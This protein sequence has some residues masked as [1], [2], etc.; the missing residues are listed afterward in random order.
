[1]DDDNTLME[2][3][4]VASSR[5]FALT[6]SVARGRVD[7]GYG[8]QLHN[9]GDPPAD[10]GP[11]TPSTPSSG[12]GSQALSSLVEDGDDLVVTDTPKDM[13]PSNSGGKE[14]LRELLVS[15]KLAS[16]S[17]TQ[18]AERLERITRALEAK[19]HGY[20][21]GSI[22]ALINN[23]HRVHGRIDEI[24]K[25][26]DRIIKIHASYLQKH[27][28]MLKF[29]YMACNKPQFKQDYGIESSNNDYALASAVKKRKV[30]S[31]L[32]EL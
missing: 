21:A 25:E 23:T 3:L 4:D 19:G 2:R 20:L 11:R 17:D 5:S 28:R 32:G 30:T 13:R 31:E 12:M 1:M 22:R 29:C 6:S 27:E 24:E 16:L 26:Y 7:D 18:F 8:R 10:Q 9:S 15:G 14:E